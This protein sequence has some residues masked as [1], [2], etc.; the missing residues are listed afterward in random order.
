MSFRT[1]FSLLAAAAFAASALAA[2]PAA[3]T[4]VDVTPDADRWADADEATI[5]PSVYTRTNGA[6]CTS[7]F[8][9][10]EFTEVVDADGVVVDVVRD[11]YIGYAA[12][13]AGL[14]GSTDTNGCVAGSEPL[15]TEV[16]VDGATEPGTLAYSS[17]HMMI[18]VGQPTD[19]NACR[20]NDFALIRLDPADHERVNPTVPFFGG[21]TALGGAT[22]S[23]DL[24]VSMGNSGLR[25]GIEQLKPK[26][27]LSLGMEGGGWTHRLYALSPGIPGD[28]GS[29]HMTD[30]GAAMGISSTL[31]LLPYAGSN[32]VTDLARSLDYMYEHTSIRAELAL[33]TEPF[34][35]RLP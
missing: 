3:P 9:F 1:T 29:G 11:V 35:T 19:S 17:W 24:V 23:G 6:G 5:R 4:A 22:G 32:G 8:I 16:Q 2:A 10:E 26:Y 7:N 12:H 15:G 30:D 25:A 13:C 18:E 21:P 27:E 31:A 20:H 34:D 33:G 28:S 14:G